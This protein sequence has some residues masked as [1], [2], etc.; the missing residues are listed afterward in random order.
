MAP[1]TYASRRSLPQRGHANTYIYPAQTFNRVLTSSHLQSG[2]VHSGQSVWQIVV[3]GSCCATTVVTIA[4]VA[5]RVK[6]G[7][8]IPRCGE[9]VDMDVCLCLCGARRDA[10]VLR[11]WVPW[12]GGGEAVSVRALRI[13]N[14]SDCAVRCRASPSQFVSPTSKLG[15]MH[16]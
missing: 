1:Q 8:L 9:D 13:C 3:F 11:G 16:G 10:W 12:V 6:V 14:S 2:A 7:R 15:W 4:R 5:R